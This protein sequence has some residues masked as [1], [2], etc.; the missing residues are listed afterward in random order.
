[1]HDTMPVCVQVCTMYT[2]M[3]NVYKYVHCT[4]YTSMYNVIQVCTM[5]TSMYNVYKYVQ[6]I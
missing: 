5:Y 1:M 4:M 6:C 3:Y 2:S